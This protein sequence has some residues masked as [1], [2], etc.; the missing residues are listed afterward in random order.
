MLE[1]IRKVVERRH[2]DDGASSVEYGLLVAAIAAIII[3]VVF[4]LG[5][6]VRGAFQGT[7][8]GIRDN[9]TAPAV[10]GNDCATN[11]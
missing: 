6:W 5:S 3:L 7:C 10:A 2:G 11:Q 9:T 1:Y 8:E 4:A